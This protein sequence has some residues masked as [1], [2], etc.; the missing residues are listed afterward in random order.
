M[1]WFYLPDENRDAYRQD[2]VSGW[3]GF[4]NGSSDDILRQEAAKERMYI[5]HY[6]D[7]VKKTILQNTKS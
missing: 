3:V 1:K 5:N 7:E 6:S 4:L 2:V